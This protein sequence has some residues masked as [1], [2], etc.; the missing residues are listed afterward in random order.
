MSSMISPGVAIDLLIIGS[1]F[2]WILICLIV[3]SLMG[4]FYQYLQNNKDDSTG[5]ID[6]T[7]SGSGNNETA[8]TKEGT[9][10]Y[11]VL[12]ADVAPRPLSDDGEPGDDTIHLGDLRKL[13]EADM[14]AC[15]YCGKTGGCMFVCPYNGKCPNPL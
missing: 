12:G 14:E 9:G 10:S 15:K 3:A 11:A 1:I 7:A 2:S 6:D 5:D 8:T 4:W 13:A